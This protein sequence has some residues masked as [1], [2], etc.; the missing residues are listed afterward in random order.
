MMSAS[1]DCGAEVRRNVGCHARAARGR[2]A[3]IRDAREAGFATGRRRFGDGPRRPSPTRPIRCS[4]SSAATRGSA[5]ADMLL[6]AGELIAAAV[7]ADELARRASTR[8]R[9]PAR[10]PASSPMARHG[11]ATILR[12]EPRRD[13]RGARARR[14]PVIAGFQGATEDGRDHDARARRNGSLGDRDRPRAGCRTRRYLHRRQRRDDRRS[15]PHCRRA[16]DRA[17]VARRDDRAGRTRRQG[18]AP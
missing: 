5:N 1:R 16:H 12:V 10:R 18:D 13:L 6:A 9:C 4:R 7:F 17:R 15:A 8:S 3:R 14:V 11:D 2:F